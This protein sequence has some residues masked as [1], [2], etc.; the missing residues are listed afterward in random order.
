MA[1]R[2]DNVALFGAFF[3]AFLQNA[4]FNANFHRESPS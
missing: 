1:K 3:A 4:A 2:T